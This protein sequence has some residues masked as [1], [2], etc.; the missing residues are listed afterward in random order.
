[1]R[2]NKRPL[3]NSAI[4]GVTFAVLAA[5]ANAVTVTFD[6]NVLAPDTFFDP[7][8]NATFTD[9]GITFDH[10]W[11]TTFDCCWGNFT[12]SNRTD[13][14]TAGFTNDRSAITGVGASG[15]SNYGV[16]FGGGAT[17]DFGPAVQLVGAEFTNTTYAYLSMLNGD[18]LVD[19]FDENDFFDL[20]INGLDGAGNVISSTVFALADGTD[21]VDQ[22]TFVDL[23]VLGVVK[24]LSFSYSG[25]DSSTFP[26]GTFLDIPTYFAIDNI[27]YQVVPVPAAGWLF[28]SA[29][30]AL[31]AR[32]NGVAAVVS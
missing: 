15:S 28:L 19:A 27:E 4:A 12:Y 16:S 6:D 3:I 31:I 30:V 24:G 18:A 11:N 29:L 26:S 25:S 23:S 14:T 7:Q 8:A 17:I 22:W 32:R 21:I 9:G 13:T 1:M 20:T 5:S 2:I 10:S